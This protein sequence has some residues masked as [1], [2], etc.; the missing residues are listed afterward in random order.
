MAL[1][2]LAEAK[3]QLN[4]ETSADDAELLAYIDALTS[5]IEQ[6][7]GPV[8]T[9]QVTETIQGR[10][11][12][13]CLTHIPAVALVSV[14]P[15]IPAGSP[16]DLGGLLLDAPTGIVHHRTGTFAGTLWIAVYTAGRSAIPPTINLAARLLLQHLWRTQNGSAR[17]GGGADDYAVTEPIPG[18]GYAVPN[19][20]LELLEPFKLPPGV[21]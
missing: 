3:A 2:T 1:L 12:R 20:V 4:I 15:A 10:S 8:E 6:H 13:I 21:A 17:G 14:T 11:P 18:F 7:V 19:R 9:R 5:V 16:L